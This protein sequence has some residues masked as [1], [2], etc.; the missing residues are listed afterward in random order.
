MTHS[1]SDSASKTNGTKAKKAAKRAGDEARE[2][3]A[4]IDRTREELGE[5]VGALV[6]KADVKARARDT[7][8]QVRTSVRD[9]AHDVK[10]GTRERAEKLTAGA[11]DGFAAARTRTAEFGDRTRQAVQ[12]P[13]N[14]AKV[15]GGGAAVAAGTAALGLA[16]WA[17]RRR[18]RPRTPWQ[19]ATHASRQAFDQALAYGGAALRGD[20][21]AQAVAA[22][23]KA[24]RKASR[25]ARQQAQKAT[26]RARDL[27]PHPT[28]KAGAALL[29][30]TTTAAAALA[31]YRLVRNTEG[32]PA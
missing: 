24:G 28:P 26:G 25:R 2:L 20:R 17:V 3:R 30:A 32:T 29:A 6:A 11:Q 19:K 7:A 31:A 21:A 9:T 15:R 12:D 5:T 1:T 13:E 10:E 27:A 16:V 18:R 8:D 4:G 14:K 22:G 23:R